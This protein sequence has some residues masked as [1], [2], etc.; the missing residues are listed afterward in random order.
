MNA[1][2]L[3]GS[4]LHNSFHSIDW[5]AVGDARPPNRTPVAAAAPARPN[6]AN[7]KMGASAHLIVIINGLRF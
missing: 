7:K 2:K 4:M 3:A 1:F 5:G 6:D